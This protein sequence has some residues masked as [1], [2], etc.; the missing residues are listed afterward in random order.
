MSGALARAA[1]AAAGYVAIGCAAIGCVAMGGVAG[2][3]PTVR[4]GD[5]YRLPLERAAAPRAR[6]SA[7]WRVQPAPASCATVGAPI[8]FLPAL[9]LTQHSWAGV[10]A[11]LGA[12][13][14]RV[15]VDLPGVGESPMVADFT[16]DEALDAITDVI[17]AVAPDGGRVVLVGHSL[18]G[19]IA[20]RLAARL[21]TRVEALVLVAAAVATF[22]LNRWEKLLLQPTLWPPLLHLAG[23]WTGVRLGLSKVE[24]GADRIP[25]VDLGLIAAEWS[26][27]RRR[28]ASR[29]YYDAFVAGDGVLRNGQALH[30]ARTNT[31]CITGSADTIVPATPLLG[32][33]VCR[34]LVIAGAGH[35]MPLTMPARIA[36]EIDGFL[37]TVAAPRQPPPVSAARAQVTREGARQP[38]ECVWSPRRE[39]FP[40][41]GVGALFPLDGRVDLSFHA[42]L[43]RGGID[44][45]FPVESGRVAL[46]VGAAIRGDASGWQFAYLQATGRLELIWRWL[47]GVHVDG[48]LL[49]DPRN[50]DVGGYGAVGYAP[51]VVPWVRAFVGGGALPGGDGRVLIGVDV[52]A[53]VTGLLF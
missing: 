48:S 47:G 28:A 20:A 36:A 9:G 21:G 14:P 8:V 5:F 6:L 13:R 41:V 32:E 2:C 37:A 10:T 51:S 42:G 30:D 44:P 43:A 3:A 33:P 53:R 12:C 50:G 26:D 19:A 31:L 49:V 52:T 23:D 15:L 40:L 22:P 4:A 34:P 27:H 11:A 25:S 38:G 35:L 17:D 24:K 18:G 7:R 29:T 45:T 16:A 1:L 39:L 46:L